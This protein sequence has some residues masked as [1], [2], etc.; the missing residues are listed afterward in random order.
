LKNLAPV[1]YSDFVLTLLTGTENGTSFRL[2]IGRITIGRGA[3]NDIVI[4]DDQKISRQHAAVT[5]TPNGVEISDISDRNVVIVN[6]EEVTTTNIS[7]GAIIQLGKTKLQLKH[8]NSQQSL[9]LV[10]AHSQSDATSHLG[11]PQPQHRRKSKPN[12]FYII[13]AVIILGLVWLLSSETKKKENVELR[14]QSDIQKSI[15]ANSR[16]IE[17]LQSDRL[18]K[19]FKSKQYEE[20]QTNFIK[21]FRDYRKGQYERAIESFQACLSLFPEHAQCLRYLPLSQKKFS[22]LVQYHMVLASKY[23]AQNQ[24][25]ACKSSYRNVMIMIKNTTDKTYIEAKSGFDTCHALEGDRF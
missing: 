1:P 17:S 8:T 15:E 14:T 21:G 13:I 9:G 25:A 11:L 16:L 19:G 20:A 23:R 18:S 4:K 2:P 10:S 6:N 12:Y 22:E 3:D 7:A 24:F 5:I